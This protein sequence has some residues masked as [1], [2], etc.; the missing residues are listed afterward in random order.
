MHEQN[1]NIVITVSKCVVEFERDYLNALAIS[2]TVLSL[3]QFC[4][5]VFRIDGSVETA[6]RDCLMIA[7]T[8]EHVI[9]NQIRA[10][11][12]FNDI[13]PDTHSI[14]VTCK[15]IDATFIIYAHMRDFKDAYRVENFVTALAPTNV[16]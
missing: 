9:N 1:V 4:M 7:R 13:H 16:N 10:L 14:S 11:L 12:L 3:R 8:T 5:D 6:I 2:S 15:Y